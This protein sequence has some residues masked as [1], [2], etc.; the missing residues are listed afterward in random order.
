MFALIA[1]VLF[2]LSPFVPPLGP[3]P[4]VTLGLA[5]L[6]LHLMTGGSW[7]PWRRHG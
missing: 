7:P 6:A 4:L 1:L 2:L 3:W 5:C